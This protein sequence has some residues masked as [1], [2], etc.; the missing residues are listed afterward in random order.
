MTDTLP[1]ME[2][3][4][5]TGGRGR[6][7]RVARVVVHALNVARLWF[8]AWRRTRPFWGAVWTL[9]AGAEIV[10][11]MSFSF[12]LALTG[13][14]AY[15]AGYVM[16]GGLILMGLTALFAPHYKSLAGILA[17]V[18]ALG[19]FPTANLGGYLLGSV[20]GIIGASMIWSWGPKRPTRRMRRVARESDS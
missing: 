20:L 7:A 14:W 1:R 11:L 10:K 3:P 8:R 19:A 17:F 6:A 13:G 5:G 12:G 18:I 16:G 15:S 9:L 4:Q 2:A